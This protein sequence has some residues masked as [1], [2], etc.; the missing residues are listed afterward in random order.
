MMLHGIVGLCF[1]K[2]TIDSQFGT[3]LDNC[4]K[5]GSLANRKHTSNLE[6][7]IVVFRVIMK[8]RNGIE[9]APLPVSIL[10]NII[11]ATTSSVAAS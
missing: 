6:N 1:V 2:Q 5:M 11:S 7:R 10:M 9:E 4:W 3:E 8:S